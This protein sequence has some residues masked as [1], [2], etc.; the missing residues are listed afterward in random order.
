MG[1]CVSYDGA[2]VK[3]KKNTG[4]PVAG[5]VIILLAA[6]VIRF[7]Y[8]QVTMFL[9]QAIFTEQAV[10]AFTQFTEQGREADDLLEAFRQVW[11]EE[12]N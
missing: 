3:K 7:V 11:T 10:A 6:V 12:I 9:R 2:N 4:L 1:Y 5:A 8:P